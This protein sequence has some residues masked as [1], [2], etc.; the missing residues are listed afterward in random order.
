MMNIPPQPPTPCL[1]KA[2]QCNRV[3]SLLDFATYD[4]WSGEVHYASN[5]EQVEVLTGNQCWDYNAMFPVPVFEKSGDS[6]FWLELQVHVLRGAVG[7]GFE[8][9]EDGSGEVRVQASDLP[10]TLWFPLPSSSS[11]EHATLILRNVFEHGSSHLFVRRAVIVEQSVELEP[12]FDPEQGWTG[13]SPA[14]LLPSQVRQYTEEGLLHLPHFLPEQAA[15][16]TRTFWAECASSL[17][18]SKQLHYLRDWHVHHRDVYDLCLHPSLTGV[19]ETL[20]GEPGLLWDTSFYIKEPGS[21]DEIVWH[22]DRAHWTPLLGEAPALSMTLVLTEVDEYNGGLRWIPGSHC[23]DVLPLEVQRGAEQRRHLGIAHSLLP[24]EAPKVAR[25]SSGDVVF[26]HPSLLHCSSV[27]TTSSVRAVFVAR[28]VAAS[29]ENPEASLALSWNHDEIESVHPRS[30]RPKACHWPPRHW[31]VFPEA[32]TM[33]ASLSELQG[34]ETV[35][36][37]CSLGTSELMVSPLGLGSLVFGGVIGEEDVDALLTRAMEL[38]LNFIDTA[39]LYKMGVSEWLIGRWLRRHQ[40]PRESLVLATKGRGAM[41]HPLPHEGLSRE[42]LTAALQG[43][44]ER[45]GTEYIDLYQLHWFD[46]DTPL[47]E[48]LE[49]LQEF[50]EQGSIREYGLC[51]FHGWRLAEASM[52]CE[53]YGWKKPVSFQCQYSLVWRKPVEREYTEA[54]RRFGLSLLPY[55]P[56]ASGFLAGKYEKKKHLP[57]SSRMYSVREL[58]FQEQNWR[59]LK[60]VRALASELET[61]PSQLSLAWLRQQPGVTSVLI[62]P[63]TLEQLEDCVASLQIALSDEHLRRLSNVSAWNPTF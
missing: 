31:T 59:I 35:T 24:E 10:Q 25:W 17:E 16:F 39:N 61:T 37:R 50:L 28:F 8:I 9:G 54:C 53:R 47:E 40:I 58:H 23:G 29:V 32:R 26:H 44:L 52:L 19:V 22:Q 6:W 56:L 49:T 4:Y 33:T 30:P 3:L 18:T 12:V 20:L 21:V 2:L 60:E 41:E 42:A 46:D 45:L 13:G 48:T 7:F 5:G 11:E 27:N 15:E 57:S 62:G 55:S 38:G 63:R 43:S 51:N 36:E 1:S 34:I 14:P